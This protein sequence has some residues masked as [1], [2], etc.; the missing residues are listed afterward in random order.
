MKKNSFLALLL[1]TASPI[2]IHW[3]YATANSSNSV[4]TTWN[5]VNKSLANLLDEGWKPINQSADRAAIA[6]TRGE[7]AFDEQTYGFL[8][9]KNGKYITCF[10]TNPKVISGA[11]SQCRALN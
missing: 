10:I 7:G 8:L 4:K 2:L 5:V 11:Y 9:V 1:L 6:T 3:D